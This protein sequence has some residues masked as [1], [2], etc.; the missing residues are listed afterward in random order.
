MNE[1]IDGLRIPLPPE[2]NRQE[3]R[4]EA[5]DE[6]NRIMIVWRPEG[7]DAWRRMNDSGI[8]YSWSDVVETAMRFRWQL[9]ACPM[10]S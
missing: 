8:R 2:P 6:L 10:V 4:V 7:I 5:R 9:Y 1:V 3:C